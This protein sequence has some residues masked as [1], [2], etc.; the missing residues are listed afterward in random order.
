MNPT[1][2]KLSH[3][4]LAPLRSAAGSASDWR[5]YNSIRFICRCGRKQTFPRS[6]SGG[7]KA[8]AE[9][10][11]DDGTRKIVTHD[12]KEVICPCGMHTYKDREGFRR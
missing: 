9:Y 12:T 8:T 4:A 1:N 10:A 6:P 11:L 7:R 2:N 5:P 3:G